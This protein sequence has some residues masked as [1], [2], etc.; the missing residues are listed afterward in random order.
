M[1]LL[2][3]VAHAQLTATSKIRLLGNLDAMEKSRTRRPDLESNVYIRY[4][5]RRD[6]LKLRISLSWFE[7][8][9]R[10]EFRKAG[11]K[12]PAIGKIQRFL[13]RRN[14]SLQVVRDKKRKTVQQRIHKVVLFNSKNYM[15][16]YI[17]NQS[18][19]PVFKH[20][21]VVN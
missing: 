2:S 3:S 8:V 12:V 7:A 21:S 13:K 9:F 17:S 5:H 15:L 19:T 11:E 16:I 6:S 18:R 10:E 14:I 1:C 4:R 20:F